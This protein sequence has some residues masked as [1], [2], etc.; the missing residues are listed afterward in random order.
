MCQL[1]A[2]NPFEAIYFPGKRH[3]SFLLS[4][5]WD[6]N[7]GKLTAKHTMHVFVNQNSLTCSISDCKT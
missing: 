1:S 4:Y 3:I 6:S 2:T 7:L 5:I